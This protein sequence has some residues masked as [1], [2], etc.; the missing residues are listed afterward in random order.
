MPLQRWEYACAG[1]HDQGAVT[2]LGVCVQA[3][4]PEGT[5]SLYHYSA[6]SMLVG[7]H[8]QCAITTPKA[9]VQASGPEG[10]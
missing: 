9:C 4:G 6:G 3:S 8:D 1:E 5:R 7:E 2:A 10:A